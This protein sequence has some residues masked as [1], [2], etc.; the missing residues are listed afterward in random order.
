MLVKLMPEQISDQW[1]LV[2][3]VIVGSRPHDL[4]KYD[5]NSVL[6][7]LLLGVKD[8]WASV[9][10]K[11]VPEGMVITEVSSF[12]GHKQLFIFALYTFE[13]VSEDSWL[14]GAGT[15]VKYAQSK[16]CKGIAAYS[17]VDSV[18]K[19]TERLGG[20]A[21]QRFIYIPL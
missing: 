6:E 12:N 9:N 14:K 13:N 5:T 2:R 11:G 19:F 20:D 16:G 21:S 4:I 8:C 7:E 15:L 1:E 18:I 10:G 17:N 3:E